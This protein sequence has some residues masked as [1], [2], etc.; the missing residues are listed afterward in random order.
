MEENK[1]DSRKE[2]EDYMS[3][4]ADERD[5]EAGFKLFC[6]FS[7][8]K[9]VKSYLG[10]K[11]DRNKLFY[12]LNELLKQ[13]KIVE[14]EN[15][16]RLAKVITRVG[17]KANEV[18]GKTETSKNK[19]LKLEDLP[20]ELHALYHRIQESYKKMRALHERIKLEK[21]DKKREKTRAGID[22]LDV[23]IRSGWKV[24]DTWKETGELPA[25]KSDNATSK[26]V[27]AAKTYITKNLPKL[28]TLN[29]EKLDELVEKIKIRYQLLVK[30][31]HN[32][33]DEV[34]A[35]MK[36]FGIGAS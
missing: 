25:A 35:K 14:F 6:R 27:Q 22:K 8:N 34:L 16:P 32:F 20:E 13:S 33:T 10:R 3:V 1:I 23:D 26:E 21:N 30:E 12:K 7:R 17:K 24:I 4:K 5:Y 9:C 11:I 36:S 2:I 18:S 28:E 29:N 31:G 19:T 15:T